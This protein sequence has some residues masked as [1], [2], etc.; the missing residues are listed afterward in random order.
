MKYVTCE[1]HIG[2]FL[3][4]VWHHKP[5]Q[6]GGANNCNV[7]GG[8]EADVLQIGQDHAYKHAKHSDEGPAQHG[9]WNG[10]EHSGELA[11]QPKSYIEQSHKYKHLPATNL[12][13][14]IDICN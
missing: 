4:P 12:Q 5:Y 11:Y 3:H 7:A 9:V 1:F 10:D 13:G 6:Y 8:L 2:S 14:N